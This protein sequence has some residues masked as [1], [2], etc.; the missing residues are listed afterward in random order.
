MVSRTTFPIPLAQACGWDTDEIERAERIAGTE[1]SAYGIHWAFS[2]ASE[3][4][5]VTPGGEG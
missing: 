3:L 2:P 5:P 1:S 4:V